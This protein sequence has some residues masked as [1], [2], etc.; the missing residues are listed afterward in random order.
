MIELME[1][2]YSNIDSNIF[3][4]CALGQ[5]ISPLWGSLFAAVNGDNNNIKLTL[6]PVSEIK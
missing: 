6:R 3:S 1:E 4:P 5:A 2:Q